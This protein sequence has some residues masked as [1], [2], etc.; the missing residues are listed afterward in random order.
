M[1][2]KLGYWSIVLLTINSIIG[3]GIFLSPGSVVAIAGTF[4]PLVYLVAAIFAAILAIAFAAA[5]KYISH[6]GAAYAYAKAAFG[7]NVGFYIGI[8]RYIAACIAW[9]VMATAVIKT[10]I[11]IFHGNNSD[12][13]LITIGFCIL[14]LILL[15]INLFGPQLFEI[16]NNLS[17]IGK[18]LALITT[19]IAGAVIVIKT[20]SNHFFEIN[21]LTNAAGQPLIKPMNV[22]LF[23][24]ATIAAFY[25]FTGFESVA[26]GSADMAEPEKNLPRAIP[27]AISIIGLIYIGVIVIT[28]MVNPRALVQTKQVVALVAV[29][30]QP[31]VQNIILYGALISMLGINVAASFSTPRILEAIAQE[32]QIPQW[33]NHRT[34]NDFPLRAFLVTFTIAIILP[35]A[36]NYNMTNIIVLSSISRFIQFLVVPAAVIAFY[37]G[38]NREPI[39]PNVKKNFVTDVLFPGFGFI[40][41]GLLLIKFDWVG[42]FTVTTAQGQIKPNLFAIIAMVVGYVVLPLILFLISR[43]HQNSEK[44]K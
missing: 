24:M 25:A 31:I 41:T 36:F 19:I 30:N 34:A 33:F 13:G 21:Q 3:S 26:S 10:V 29:F 15:V 18:L 9:G 22:S 17:T 6:G 39:L 28:M 32:K 1:R 5:A 35:M 8:T 38:K 11:A 16:I 42:Q 2:K 44:A 40:L 14:L 7:R 20:G 23:V 37:Y 27:L 43:Y 12:F 4:A